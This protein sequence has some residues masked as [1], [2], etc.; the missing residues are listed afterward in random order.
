MVL[1]GLVRLLAVVAEVLVIVL[2]AA[3]LATGLAP[4]ADRLQRRPWG[5]RR[6]QLSRAAAAG[7]VY[8]GL[9]AALGLVGSLLVTPLVRETSDLV[10]RAPEL[11]GRLQ[12]MIADL[13]QRYPWLP[14]LTGFIQRLPEEAGR[15]TAYV[16]RATGVAFRV[17][18]AIVSAVTVL[19]LSFYMLLEGPAIKA[20]FL[21]LFPRRNHRQLEM[22]LTEIGRKFGG[23]L[24]GQLFLGLIVGLA[25]GL[26]TAGLG[27]P[28][29]LLLGLAAGVTELIPLVGPVLGAIPAVFVALFGPTWRLLAVIVLFVAIQQAENHFLVPR[30]TRQT[31]GLSPVL[32]LVAIMVGTKLMGILGALLAVPVA[33]AV[34]VIVGELV[35]TYGPTG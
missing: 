12:E 13:Q 33:A 16:G 10:E 30:V 23:W 19:I 18:G 27:L 20:G 25:A 4:V 29:A 24:R 5:R 9:L 32:T 6:R 35:R 34:Q 31:V 22:V 1:V 14:N 17:F 7:L 11:Y 15:L 8:L 26:G 3:I 2:I 28:Y 21:R